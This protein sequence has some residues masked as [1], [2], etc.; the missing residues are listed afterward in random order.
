MRISEQPPSQSVSGSPDLPPL[1][2]LDEMAV[3]VDELHAEMYLVQAHLLRVR[4][5]L[6]QHDAAI[7]E[8]WSWCER[9]H[10]LS[11]KQVKLSEELCAVSLE[12]WTALSGR[13]AGRERAVRLLGATGD[14]LNRA[15]A[16]L[17]AVHDLLQSLGSERSAR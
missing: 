2:T 15:G 12:S 6:D 5:I 7:G 11:G 3:E 9:S 16:R 8:A 4:G 13:A 17:Q 14:R 1:A 10:T